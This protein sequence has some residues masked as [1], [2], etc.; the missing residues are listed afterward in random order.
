[1][2]DSQKPL[3]TTQDSTSEKPSF[4]QRKINTSKPNQVKLS[5]Q[6]RGNSNQ[7]NTTS[8]P[9]EKEKRKK[10][11]KKA[12]F[13]DEIEAHKRPLVEIINIEAFKNE[14]E[15]EEGEGEEEEDGNNEEDKVVEITN[16]KNCKDCACF[17]I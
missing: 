15:E 13:C 7:I 9:P 4:E 3:T 17:I 10:I 12:R 11:N 14:N 2:E 5:L 16:E 6:K 8:S 1:M